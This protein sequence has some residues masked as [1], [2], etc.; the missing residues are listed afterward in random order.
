MPVSYYKLCGA[1]HELLLLMAFYILELH[2][3]IMRS[4]E[5]IP[6]NKWTQI[7][8]GRRHGEGYLDVGQQESVIGK[9]LGPT[10]SMYLKT[11]LYIG[12]YDKRIML[13]NGVDTNRGFEG[14]V[15]GVSFILNLICLANLIK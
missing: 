3:V 9:T 4:R 5:P 1:L 12:G 7:S 10:R 11:N 15:S 13:N 6:E 2:P 8:I 14:C